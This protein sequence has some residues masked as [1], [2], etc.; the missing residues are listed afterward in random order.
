MALKT[1]LRDVTLSALQAKQDIVLAVL[2]THGKIF[3]NYSHANAPRHLFLPLRRKEVIVFKQVTGSLSRRRSKRGTPRN[4][5][6]AVGHAPME[7]A[8]KRY[9]SIFLSL[10]YLRF[11]ALSCLRSS[12]ID[13][14]PFCTRR[15]DEN[16]FRHKKL[17]SSSHKFYGDVIGRLIDGSIRCCPK[18]SIGYG[19]APPPTMSLNQDM[20]LEG[21]MST[22]R[23]CSRIAQCKARSRG[24]ERAQKHSSPI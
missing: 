10:C 14:R 24:C 4:S 9:A 18:F 8:A 22:A 11:F 5:I 20:E 23:R 2:Y 21:E 7:F 15:L 19:V 6:S 12:E 3:A 16:G 17:R 13:F 1:S